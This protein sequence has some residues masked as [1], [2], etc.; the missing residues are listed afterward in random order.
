MMVTIGWPPISH[1]D[2]CGEHNASQELDRALDKTNTAIYVFPPCATDLVQPA[3]SYKLELIYS[4][5]WSNH[6]RADKGWSGKLKNP[7]ENIFSLMTA[8]FAF[9][10]Y[11]RCGTTPAG[12]RMKSYDPL[13]SIF[14]R[15]GFL[16]SKAAYTRASGDYRQVRESLRGRVGSSTWCSGRWHVRNYCSKTPFNSAHLFGVELNSSKGG[17]AARPDSASRT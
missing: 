16:A 3:D 17:T 6:V 11:T 10:L 8:D 15:S 4:N 12:Q 7:G 13:W 5:E 9:V 2:N 14:R 1:L